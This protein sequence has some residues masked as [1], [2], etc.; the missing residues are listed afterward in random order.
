MSEAATANESAFIEFVV[1]KTLELVCFVTVYI[2]RDESI[3]IFFRR[4][5]V[6][7]VISHQLAILHYWH[8]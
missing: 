6:D 7:G 8:I 1:A 3:P 5:R 2:S 4:V